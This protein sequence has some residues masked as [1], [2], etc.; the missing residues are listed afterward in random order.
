MKKINYSLIVSD[1]DGTLVNNDRTIVQSNKDTI[2]EYIANG[3]KFAISTGRLPAGII[4]RA[5]ELELKG[6]VSCCQGSVIVDIESKEVLLKGTIPH[7][8]TLRVCEKLEA[9][10]VHYHVYDLWDFYSNI[11]DEPLKMY[12]RMTGSK[13]IILKDKTLPEFVR[14]T[15]MEACKFLVMVAPEDNAKIFKILEAENFEG[16][17]ITKSGAVLVEI[18]NKNYS[19]GTTIEF[20]SKYYNIPIEKIIGIGDQW[21]DIPM[22]ETAGLGIAVKNADELLKKAAD[23]TFDYTNEEGAV[24]KI[25]EKYGYLEE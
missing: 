5:E 3:G 22:I 16:C 17:T 8:V 24:G 1:F 20:L 25:I 12:E 18:I 19:K 7:E 2:K 11:D 10:G 6:V 13:G 9:M 21:N 14:E 23:V 4:A 15:K